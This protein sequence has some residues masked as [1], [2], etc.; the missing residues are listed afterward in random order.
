MPNVLG[1][2]YYF[3]ALTA[4]LPGRSDALREYLE[5][6]PLGAE[7]PLARIGQAH[8]GRW[9]IIPYVV[10]EDRQEFRDTLKN[11]YLLFASDFTGE[12]D[13]FLD[14]L[15]TEMATEAD[16]IWGHCVGY[17]GTGDRAAFKRYMQ[18]NQIETSA[19]VGKYAE[20]DIEEVREALDLRERLIRFAI[21]AQSLDAA[22]L[23]E[24]YR[25]EFAAESGGARS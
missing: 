15:C 22:E 4:I 16:A 23:Q 3:Q 24:A 2:T 7:S 18:H 1:K 12:L 10:N 8:F 11:E 17:P 9:V 13:A 25:R 14:A 6:L 20:H 19:P 5:S 21:R